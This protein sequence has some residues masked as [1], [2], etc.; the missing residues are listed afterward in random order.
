MRCTRWCVLALFV[1]LAASARGQTPTP[2]SD[3]F[4]SYAPGADPATGMLGGWETWDLAALFGSQISTNHARSGAN[5]YFIGGNSDSV[6]EFKETSGKWIMTGHVYVP[7][8]AGPDQLTKG[9]WWIILNTYSPGGP[10]NWSLQ[11][12]F[13]P[14]GVTMYQGGPNGTLTTPLLADQWAE[15]RAEI[16]L[17]NDLCQV[18]YG[19]PGNAVPFGNPFQWTQGL[20]GSGIKEIQ[21]LDL[22]AND[23]NAV[24]NPNPNGGVYWDDVSLRPANTPTTAFCTA[25]TGLVCGTPAIAASGVSSATATSG[26]MISAGPARSCRNGVTIYG[27]TQIAALPF[28]GGNGVICFT[29]VRRAAPMDSGGTPGNNCDGSFVLDFNSFMA[30]AWVNGG[31][32]PNIGP[33]TNPAGFLAAGTSVFAQVWGRDSVATG[34][35]V[36]DGVSWVIGP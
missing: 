32:S 16:D 22:W 8:V 25:K 24:I 17:D 23:Q 36:S 6:Q 14:T 18:Y 12:S 34:S 20:T 11:I 7:T 26:F 5:S 27:N 21:C 31:C 15:I 4:E 28:G 29:P 3:D 13:E 9:E 10:K 1:T 30:L 2:W 35:F 19:T 33:Q